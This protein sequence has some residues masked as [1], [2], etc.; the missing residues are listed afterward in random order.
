M[1]NIKGKMGGGCQVS[2]KRKHGLYAAERVSLIKGGKQNRRTVC[3]KENVLTFRR[4]YLN[5]V[6]ER[7]EEIA[8]QEERHVRRRNIFEIENVVYINNDRDKS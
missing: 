5:K 7:H 1:E 2:G 6:E 3:E 8:S 4:I